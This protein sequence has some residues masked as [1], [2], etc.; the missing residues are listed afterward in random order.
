[1][2]FTDG[3]N[4]FKNVRTDDFPV[5]M[6]IYENDN[7]VMRHFLPYSKKILGIYSSLVE[8]LKSNGNEDNSIRNQDE[9]SDLMDLMRN[10]LNTM[11]CLKYQRMII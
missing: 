9:Y 7:V 3:T 8:F 1:M 2:I 11:N 4:P 5:K 6:K 10:H